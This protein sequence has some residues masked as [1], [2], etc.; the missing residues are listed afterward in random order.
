MMR[1]LLGILFIIVG[2]AMLAA[3]GMLLS[4]NVQEDSSARRAADSRL[5]KLRDEITALAEEKPNLPEIY[6]R[7]ERISEEDAP[8]EA[9]T[10][11]IDGT[12][13]I[14]ILALPALGLELPVT[15]D[16]SYAK[17]R[18]GPCRY[19]GSA[20]TEDLVI[21]GHN[22]M[23]VFGRLREM[24]TG[25]GVYFTEADGTLHSY[26]VSETEI[27]EPTAIEEMTE[28]DSALTLYTCTFG[29][30]FR[31]TVRCSETTQQKQKQA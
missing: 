12:R 24:N 22:Y 26:V 10:V 17:L 7:E 20:E 18:S 8:Y 31:V 11:E 19:Y 15:A 9:E 30:K 25:D 27:L 1:K 21:C 29:G 16:W 14:G 6:V 13:Y 5:P 4:R 3:G 2:I 28:S 23:S